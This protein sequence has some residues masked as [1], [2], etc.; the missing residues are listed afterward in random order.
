M[1]KTLENSITSGSLKLSDFGEIT[2]HNNN[3]F[4]LKLDY[5]VDP[6]NDQSDFKLDTYFFIPHSFRIDKINY[7]K[8]NFYEDM[9]VYIRFKPILISLKELINPNNDLSPI[10]RAIDQLNAI[11]AGDNT[12]VRIDTIIHELKTL[13]VIVQ[14]V[15]SNHIESIYSLISTEPVTLQN[16][17]DAYKQSEILIEQINEFNHVFRNKRDQFFSQFV[18]IEVKE[19]FDYVL[20]YIF[21][22]TY[23]S[24]TNFLKYLIENQYKD[25][26][27]SLIIPKVKKLLK[28]EQVFR[29]K[30]GFLSDLRKEQDNERFTYRYS[31]L[32]K[33]ISDVL[34]LKARPEKQRRALRELGY[35]IAAG[36][37]MLVAVLLTF[38]AQTFFDEYTL[39][40][41]IL[42]VVGY[43]IK[44][45][46]KEW[47]R[48]ITGK[49]FTFKTRYDYKSI[50]KDS[51]NIKIGKTKEKFHF[52]DNTPSDIQLS[53]TNL[54]LTNIEE[55][56]K[57]ENII[58][59]HKKITLY[60]AKIAEHHERV[61][62]AGDIIRFDINNFLSKIEDPYNEYDWYNEDTEKIEIIKA[63]RV[64][65]LNVI[66][67][68]V[69]LVDHKEIINRINR[70]RIVVDKRGI[71]RIENIT[72]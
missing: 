52:I 38:L 2:I 10:Y 68:F 64:Y 70:L 43:M 11:I 7:T 41:I 3:L 12:T 13:A 28:E 49:G 42:I 8:N 34:Y 69:K 45:R 53:R 51:E 1:V 19:T 71:K 54:Q 46:L 6:Q 37:A 18:P 24:M 72:N 16:I 4:E 48:I 39:P 58:H 36:I 50:I 61:L 9:Q 29:K 40:F 27:I 63:A 22:Y 14:T 33:Y 26:K 47:I 23:R 67:K 60:P 32:K 59:Y 57:P 44:D 35:A 20:E 25:E 31:I 15:I 56:G 65:H 66:L 17:T 5:S 55:K 21:V 30:C 62:D